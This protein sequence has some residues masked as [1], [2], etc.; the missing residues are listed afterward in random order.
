MK[1]RNVA[2]VAAETLSLSA[3]TC[4]S[5]SITINLKS[6]EKN[7]KEMKK[8]EQLQNRPFKGVLGVPHRYRENVT[9]T[10]VP[11]DWIAEEIAALPPAGFVPVFAMMR[12]PSVPVAPMIPAGI[13]H[14][15]GL[16]LVFRQEAC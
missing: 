13:H 10:A 14:P 12:T 11:A 16:F 6:K 2:A 9:G 8:Y 7:K 15:D 5:N 3:R 1:A 4:T